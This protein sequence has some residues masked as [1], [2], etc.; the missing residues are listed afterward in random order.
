MPVEGTYP[1]PLVYDPTSG[2]H[3]HTI[4]LLHGRGG[5]A[6]AFGPALLSTALPVADTG[7]AI[8]EEVSLHGRKLGENS[9]DPNRATTT[10][11]TLAQALPHA[12]FIFP[13]APKQRATVYKR[14]II[15]QWFDDWHLGGF[16][17]DEVD[18][19]YD[20]GLQTGGM[21][22]TVGYLHDL[23]AREAEVVGGARNV[24]LGGISQ[25]CAVSLVAALLWEGGEGLCGVVGM[26]GWLPF[27]AQ[28]RG[29]LGVGADGDGVDVVTAGVLGQEALGGFDPFDRAVPPE[30][31]AESTGGS[32]TGDPVTAALEWLRDEIEV[33]GRRPVAVGMRRRNSNTPA[34]LCHGRDDGKVDIAKGKEA[35]DFLPALGIGPVRFKAYAGVEHTWSAEMVLDIVDFVQKHASS[36]EVPTTLRY[37]FL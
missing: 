6:D 34:I 21:G 5:S 23:I 26:C 32:G 9:C 8:P 35:A 12:R 7:T 15:R 4:I 14:S 37:T 17:G 33:P 24:I 18:G 2:V 11:T 27:V 30:R 29:H 16:A 22:R 13:T 1:E 20:M 28:M 10:T 3:K 25:G 36:L 31:D 19:R